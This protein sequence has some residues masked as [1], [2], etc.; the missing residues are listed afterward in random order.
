MQMFREKGNIVL[1]CLGMLRGTVLW[2]SIT[3]N[4]SWMAGKN[5]PVQAKLC[6]SD[7]HPENI[8]VHSKQSVLIDLGL[9]Q[10][11]RMI[12]L[13]WKIYRCPL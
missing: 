11:R 4:I 9:L 13:F 2:E 10:A 1:L 5:V 12:A 3:Q 8:V 7:I 6:I